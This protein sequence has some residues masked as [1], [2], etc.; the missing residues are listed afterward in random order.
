MEVLYLI[1]HFVPQKVFTIISVNELENLKLE[2]NDNLL[3]QLP[4]NELLKLI[5]YNRLGHLS[6]NNNKIRFVPGIIR[7]DIYA[8]IITIPRVFDIAA[9]LSQN[10]K[11]SHLK[12][13]QMLMHHRETFLKLVVTNVP[14]KSSVACDLQNAISFKTLVRAMP[15]RAN[16]R[17]RLSIN[18]TVIKQSFFEFL[19]SKGHFD[20]HLIY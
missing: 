1:A 2:F 12:I 19:S 6:L 14:N 16:R 10:F 20:W 9:L 5:A 4:C 18:N 8:P 13:I 11:E 7:R 15:I 3:L 17:A